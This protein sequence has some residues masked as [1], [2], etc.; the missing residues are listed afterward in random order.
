MMK[1]FLKKIIDSVIK[2]LYV[3]GFI[4]IRFMISFDTLTNFEFSF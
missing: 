4:F 1:K 3:K 2:I